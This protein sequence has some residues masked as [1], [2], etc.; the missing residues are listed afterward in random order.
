MYVHNEA[1][2]KPK[3]MYELWKYVKKDPN[4]RFYIRLDKLKLL[5]AQKAE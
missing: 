2:R 5:G 3:T 4:V 1:E